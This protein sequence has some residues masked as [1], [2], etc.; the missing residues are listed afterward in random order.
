MSR[1]LPRTRRWWRLGPGRLLLASKILGLGKHVAR[2]FD[3]GDKNAQW[4]RGSP[5]IETTETDISRRMSWRV[6]VRRIPLTLCEA[7][8]GLRRPELNLLHDGTTAD[9]N[10]AAKATTFIR[11]AHHRTGALLPPITAVYFPHN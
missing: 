5:G 6:E 9:S 8:L 4:F 2:L 7:S 10:F 3:R 1:L 11:R